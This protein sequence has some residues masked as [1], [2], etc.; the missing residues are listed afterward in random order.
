MAE[1]K[2]VLRTR[3]MLVDALLKLRQTRSFDDI[4]VTDI[5]E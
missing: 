4:S 1:S 5:C 2:Q 3:K